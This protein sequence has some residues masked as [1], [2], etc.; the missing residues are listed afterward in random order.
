METMARDIA[1][2][3]RPSQ[4]THDASG[5]LA[6][7]AKL[8]DAYE[9]VL[10]LLVDANGK[11]IVA[12]ATRSGPSRE[13]AD[14]LAGE[15]SRRLL[16]AETSTFDAPD[17]LDGGLVFAVR[18]SDE[19]ERGI[20]GGVIRQREMFEQQF[21]PLHNAMSVCGV[22]A[23]NI[24]NGRQAEVLSSTRIQHLLAEQDTLRASHAKAV[25]SAIEEREE[26][27]REQREYVTQLQTVM[28]MAA[29]GI[30]TTDE[31]GVIES[32]NEAAALIFGYSAEEV[33]GRNV[34]MLMPSPY[35]ERH[36]E[37]L[38]QYVKAE[39]TGFFS[40]AR[41]VTGQ[42]R[43]GSV[44]P[45]ELA[46]SDVV[47]G[48]RRI[49]TVI[50]RDITQRR[51]EEEELKRLHLQ[52]EMIL[53]SAG[54]GIVGLDENGNVTFVNPAGARTLGR[55][56][57]E[58]VGKMYHELSH[59]SKSNGDPYPL[60]ECPV[61]KTLRDGDVPRVDH[62]VFWRSNGTSFPIEYT[63]TPIREEGK[64]TGV[65]V[66]FRDV[67]E[68]RTLES[69]LVQAQKLES[70]GQ[71]AAGVAHEI[72]TPT[73]YIG[74]NTRFLQDTFQDLQ[75]LLDS[76]DGLLQSSRE[77]TVTDELLEAVEEAVEQADLEYLV[78]EM[79]K[80]IEQSLDG[81]QRVATI[82]RSMKEFSHPAGA[83]MQAVDINRAIENTL[84]VSRNEWKYV[85]DTVTDL[86]PN[87]P[88]VV[89]LPGECN[90]VFLNLVINA[91]HAIGE[92][93]GDGSTSEK[94]TI[95]VATRRDGDWVE[96]RVKDTGTG[97]PEEI[98]SKILD[99]FFTTK[100][101]GRGTG[102][103]L[104]IA[105]SVVVEKH[106]GTLTFDTQS[107][108]GTTFIVRLPIKQES[109]STN[110]DPNEEANPVC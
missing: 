26:R 94:G 44:F 71:L 58:L 43:D 7:I 27:L 4:P 31:T 70:I 80:A 107:N 45:L 14:S 64:I 33:I 95:T 39:S 22:L 46:V 85:A 84:I 32:F 12:H 15:M 51:K 75:R 18:L 36:G 3:F 92:K 40:F 29:D 79:P 49:F 47:I 87:L 76:Y 2:M 86:D 62:E 41:E 35:C 66:T 91:A 53:N 105:H 82:V 90:Q 88:P 42:R 20:L 93:S 101:V 9:P 54:E 108:Q 77:G 104:A 57:D 102:Q 67:T 81:V 13:A 99:P 1:D 100:E 50:L 106:G 16:D 25:S 110:S 78:E 21:G 52:T 55:E 6:S 48:S 65:V 30:V 56:P 73:Q 37:H 59:H 83:Q 19:A 103:G 24:I 97:I 98:R 69:Q 11:V 74:D 17:D 63:S 109:A 61:H 89:C 38:A 28:K 96:I 34:S 8:L 5:S 60:E 10:V 68:K 72:N 23:W